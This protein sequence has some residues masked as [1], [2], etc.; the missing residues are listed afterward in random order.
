MEG[1][2]QVR[3]VFAGELLP[4]FHA[5]EVKRR[6]G[7]AFK[8]EGARLAAMFSGERTV[9]KRAMSPADA[10]RYVAQLGKMGARVLVEPL[11]R[12]P[13]APAAAAR[14]PL[15]AAPAITLAPLQEEI[16]CPNCGERQPKQV[17]CR[18]CTTDMP[19]G[20]ASKK[21]D[22][23][24]AR[25]ERLDAARASRG[26]YAPPGS[27]SGVVHSG[28]EV[29]PPPML[30]L[31]F[32]GRFGRISYL[33][34]GGV[35]WG[36]IALMGII[37]A[38]MIPLLGKLV[39]VPLVL[40]GLLFFIWTFRV[41]ALRLHDC[42]LSGWWVLLMLVPYVGSLVGLVLLFIPGSREDNNYGE[43]PRQGNAVLAIV[44]VVLFVIAM[45]AALT[46]GMS[47]Y[48]Q[49][50]GRAAQRQVQQQS[51]EDNP[52][53][54]Q[55]ATQSLSSDAARE[56][57][58]EYIGQPDPKAFAVGGAGAFG[59]RAGLSS[60]REAATQA[61]SACDANRKAYT[62]E[63]RLVNVNGAWIKKR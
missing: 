10:D 49:Y 53:A 18:S 50:S 26:R 31:S 8:I 45:V 48:N 25:A 39:F 51:D 32:E 29:D 61:V 15:A 3:L 59:W 46:V 52:A 1:G 42:N 57:F 44:L 23:D 47:A 5:D 11:E 30:S 21:E 62:S 58:A 43:K 33:N 12:A 13:A 19:R 16:A 63:C 7:E 17:F 54:T 55:G 36:G 20:I 40:A 14:P 56:A 22:A 34:A 27:A 4:G 6:F 9:I 38:V 37:A 60:Q 28:G 2:A 35:A 24:R 41:T